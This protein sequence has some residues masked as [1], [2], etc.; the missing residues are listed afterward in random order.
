[1][2]KLEEKVLQEIR[3]LAEETKEL[4]RI[5]NE[6]ILKIKIVSAK[7]EVGGSVAKGTWLKGNHDIDIYVKFNPKIYEGKDISQMLKRNLAKH[8]DVDMIHGSRDYYQIRHGTYTVEIIPILDIRKVSQAKNITDVSPFHVKWVRKHKELTDDI[9]LAKAFCKANKIYGAESY[10]KGFSGYV[11]EILTTHYGSFDSLIKH[12]AKWGAKTVIDVENY[13][14]G[15][16]IDK[17][18]NTA[19][20]QSPL[21]LIDPVQKERNAAAGLDKE[22]YENFK[23]LAKNFLAN[24]SEDYFVRKKIEIENLQKISKG[25]KLVLIEAEPLEGKKDVVGAKLMKFFE[26]VERHMKLNDFK[27]IDKGWEWE[28]DNALYYF[29]LDKKKLSLT[30]K[31]YGPHKSSKNRMESFKARWKGKKIRFENNI[32]YVIIEREYRDATKFIKDFVKNEFVKDKI[33]KVR[34]LQF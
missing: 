13:Y 27:A 22:K 24:P 7:S 11:L 33:K 9:R 3:P 34:L 10:I 12:A 31:H 4:E 20:V 26:S 18:L 30:K 16:N 23:S 29:I 25:K 32:S 1:M 15:K 14:K 19:K 17:E 8:Y 5:G 28:G 2:N 21:I 6:I